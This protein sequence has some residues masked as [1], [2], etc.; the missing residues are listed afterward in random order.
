MIL[1]QYP[2]R[3]GSGVPSGPVWPEVGSRQ[4][5]PYFN[6]LDIFV[7][8]KRIELSGQAKSFVDRFGNVPAGDGVSDFGSRLSGAYRMSLFR[9]KRQRC[10]PDVLLMYDDFYNHHA[11]LF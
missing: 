5:L 4:G 6:L 11:P 1:A 2:H 7:E 10:I 9:D 8:R 3:C